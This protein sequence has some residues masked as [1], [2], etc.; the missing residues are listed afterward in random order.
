VDFHHTT[1]DTER[2]KYY[3]ETQLLL[4][5]YEKSFDKVS[6]TKLWTIL[7]RKAFKNSL[8]KLF[9]AYTYK[10]GGIRQGSPLS[11]IPFTIYI[12]EAEKIYNM[13]KL[14]KQWKFY[15]TIAVQVVMDGLE[16]WTLTANR[17][18]RVEAVDTL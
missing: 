2:R 11:P 5:D 12:S 4:V 15:K 6:R 17:K 10:Y 18:N 7:T 13:E 1:D 16:I 14:Q 8:L 9:K 3:L